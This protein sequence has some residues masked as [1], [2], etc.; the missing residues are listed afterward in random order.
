MTKIIVYENP[1]DTTRVSIL[2]P[3]GEVTIDEL[4]QIYI[5][6]DKPYKIMEDNELPI[7]DSVYFGAWQLIDNNVVINM[8]KAKEIHRNILRQ[9][10]IERFA[11]L[12]IAFMRALEQGDMLK[13]QDIALQ[14]QKLRDIPFH[15]DIT[16]AENTVK[17]RAL[18][19]DV[20]LAN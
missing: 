10:R 20:L 3:T 2:T 11:S 5:N 16:T 6:T 14:K 18:T 12:D 15:V 8:E 9:Q 19:L 17:L 13:Q 1:E 4:L 7:E